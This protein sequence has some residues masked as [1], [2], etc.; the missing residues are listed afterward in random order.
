M[1]GTREWSEESYNICIGCEHGCLYCYAKANHC[2]FDKNARQPGQWEKQQ[3][4][5][6]RSRLG[7][8]V[9]THG[10]VMFPSSHD[11]VPRFA[12]ECLTTI[13][14][15]LVKN[16]VLVVTKPHLS[17]I[18]HLCKNLI[19]HKKQLL[20][21]FTIGSLDADLCRFWEPGAPGPAERFKALEHTRHSGYATSV[22]IE[23]ML[24]S[25]EGTIKV[26]ERVDPFVTDSIW[27]GKMQRIPIKNNHHVAD[28]A[29][30]RERIRSHQRDEEILRLVSQLRGNPKV[31]WKDS[32]Q[33]IL[34]KHQI[35]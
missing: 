16:F 3:L 15:L 10:V 18:R 9:G 11:I 19:H 35:Q 29:R 2:R 17:V 1:K 23:P 30:A 33:Q 32:I 4:N 8:G 28:F 5:P 6:N 26:V 24:D 13:K 31:R 27:I 34:Q 25:V 22:S 14:N 12:D 20:F 7:A 21:R